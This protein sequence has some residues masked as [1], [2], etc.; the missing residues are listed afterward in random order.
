MKGGAFTA[1][2][3][4]VINHAKVDQC[5]ENEE[6]WWNRVV[7]E[8]NG[9][10]LVAITVCRIVD[11]NTKSVNSTKAQHERKTGKVKRAKEIRKEMLTK[12]KE[13][14][15]ATKAC[16]V[17]VVGGMNEDINSNSVQ[18]FMVE[19]GLCDVFGE[20]NEVE[21][22]NKEATHEHG[23]KHIDFSLGTEG[24]M[25]IVDGTELMG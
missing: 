13:E 14:I 1:L 18:Q 17:L 8:D 5:I 23:P 9:K 6:G 20:L 22:R 7:L 12:L 19:F 21:E 4:D 16:D 11:A 10:R 3:N 15:R 2:W 24:V 25:S